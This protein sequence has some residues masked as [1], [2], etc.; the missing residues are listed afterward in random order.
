M[1]KG[2]GIMEA[3]QLTIHEFFSIGMFSSPLKNQLSR[4]H[5]VETLV[6]VYEIYFFPADWP[7]GI[8]VDGVFYASQKDSVCVCKPGQTRQMTMPLQCYYVYL[9][10]QDQHLRQALNSLPTFSTHPRMEE[11][12][13][14][15]KWITRRVVERHTPDTRME[16][17]AY[18]YNILTMLLRQQNP[19]SSAVNGNPRRHQEIL[20]SANQYL[21]DHFSEDIDLGKLAQQTNLSPTY[22]HK[23]FT[24]AFG[25]TPAQQLER[26]RHLAAKEYLRDDDCPLSE[27][28]RKCGYSSQSYF[29]YKFKQAEGMTP[30]TYRFNR[31]HQRKKRQEEAL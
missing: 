13:G 4:H 5:L 7:G 22:F 16:M 19:I 6:S 24:S 31:R 25:L 30:S 8:T 9:S 28:A 2:G 29:C 3:P 17:A 15:C 27:V 10:S 14:I 26:Y 1:L 21:R 23:L 20:L 12:I 18:V 11:I